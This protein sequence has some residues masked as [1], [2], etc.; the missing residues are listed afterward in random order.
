MT[1]N[2]PPGDELERL[3]RQ[4]A[5]CLGRPDADARLLASCV[6][7]LR[8]VPWQQT[9]VGEPRTWERFC[10]E[11]L[12]CEAADVQEVVAG[13]VA[14]QQA[15]L[16]NPTVAQAREALR[17]EVDNTAPPPPPPPEQE[18]TLEAT[19]TRLERLRLEWLRLTP[20]ERET[21]LAWALEQQGKE[22]K[23]PRGKGR[24]K[25]SGSA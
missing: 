20:Q 13:A 7:D 10:R 19:L 16:V 24:G 17:F 3:I 1:R 22:G 6:Q 4:A 8:A 9:L 5:F 18:P 23:E 15:G 11:L 25:K 14:L 12:G 21:F 2:S